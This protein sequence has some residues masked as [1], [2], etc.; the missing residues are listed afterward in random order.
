MLEDYTTTIT[1]TYQVLMQV[2]DVS[3]FHRG[4]QCNR[5]ST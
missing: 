1:Y 2:R 4:D 3:T 5:V